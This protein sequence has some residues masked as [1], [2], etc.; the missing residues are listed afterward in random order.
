MSPILI[1]DPYITYPKHSMRFQF[2]QMVNFRWNF[3]N[4]KLFKSMCRSLSG[5]TNWAYTVDFL[6]V[7]SRHNF[8]M[9]VLKFSLLSTCHPSILTHDSGITSQLPTLNVPKLLF[10]TENNVL[11]FI[12]INF[13]MVV[14]KPR[15]YLLH[16]VKQF[17]F[18]ICIIISLSIMFSIS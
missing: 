12:W 11:K 2:A 3:K 8:E 14:Y 16:V 18:Y 13:H 15:G 1:L 6:S 4:M 5:V 10:F 9:C 7:T 17:T